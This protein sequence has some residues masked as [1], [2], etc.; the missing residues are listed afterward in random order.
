M[1]NHFFS[2]TCLFFGPGRWQLWL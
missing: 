2:E 1:L